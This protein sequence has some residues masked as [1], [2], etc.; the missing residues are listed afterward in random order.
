MPVLRSLSRTR[1][2][3]LQA[4]GRTKE[5][6]PLFNGFSLD[7][8]ECLRG[9]EVEIKSIGLRGVRVGAAVSGKARASAAESI[10]A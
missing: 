4:G 5:R 2:G 7:P 8:R 3:A 6:L 9:D 1:T 10:S